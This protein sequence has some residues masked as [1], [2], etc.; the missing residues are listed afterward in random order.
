V[1]AKLA[2]LVHARLGPK[3]V[4]TDTSVALA[5]ILKREY[6]GGLV[7]RL[8]GAALNPRQL[9]TIGKFKDPR[10]PHG[11]R[12]PPLAQ[13]GGAGGPVRRAGST[14]LIRPT[15]FPS[16]SSTTAYRAPQNAS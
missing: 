10:F 12:L 7:A 13:G 6:A 9:P 3:V 5:D 1:R 15:E 2:L 16:G 8:L 14:G 4:S 11:P